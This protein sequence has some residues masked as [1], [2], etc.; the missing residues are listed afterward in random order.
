MTK[1]YFMLAFAVVIAAMLTSCA[2]SFL[3][4]YPGGSTITE[5]QYQNMDNAAEGLVKGVY[6]KLYEYGGEHGRPLLCD[7]AL[8]V[9]DLKEIFRSTASPSARRTSSRMFPF[10]VRPSNER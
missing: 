2:D 8:S 5:E 4:Q 10:S 3:N 7:D 6:S 1:K 9:D